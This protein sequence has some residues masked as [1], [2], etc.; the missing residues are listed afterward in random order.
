MK[1]EVKKAIEYRNNLNRLTQKEYEKEVI[2]DFINSLCFKA[3]ENAG[4]LP[5]PCEI[6][7]VPLN[8]EVFLQS[9]LRDIGCVP[10]SI[11][12]LKDKTVIRF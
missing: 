6:F 4:K 7:Y 8:C 10:T 11:E 2:N 3:N 5:N 1:F 12:F 9:F